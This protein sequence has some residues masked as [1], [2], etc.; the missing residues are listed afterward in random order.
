MRLGLAVGVRLSKVNLRILRVE[1]KV[2]ASLGLMVGIGARI[3]IGV[4]V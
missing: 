3:S 2:G 1:V 4:E